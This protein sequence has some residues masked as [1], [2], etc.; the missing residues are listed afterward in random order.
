[1]ST[2]PTPTS[3]DI[4][5]FRYSGALAQD[6]E[7]RWQDRWDVEGTFE[8]PNPAGPLADGT[9]VDRP[10]RFILDMFPYPSGAGLHMGHPLGYT[11]TDI[12]A[13]Y[14]RMAGDNVIYSMGF[15]AFGLPAEQYAVQTGQHPATIP[16]AA[17]TPP[18]PAT[19]GGH[20]GSSCRSSTAGSTRPLAAPD[21][22]TTSSP[23]SMPEPALRWEAT[24]TPCRRPTGAS[25]ST[26][27]GWRTSAT[28]P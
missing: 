12:Y 4:P 6:I 17:S 27:G 25:S 1:V 8:T 16:A 14:R 24:G 13:R 7:A 23:N 21:P 19:T 9:F 3:S 22:S 15:D 2:E 10:R 18:I 5:P 26:A 20:S 11:A 28:H